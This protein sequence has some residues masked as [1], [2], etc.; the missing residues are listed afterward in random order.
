MISYTRQE[1]DFVTSMLFVVSYRT[2]GVRLAGS[3]LLQAL[4]SASWDT[5]DRG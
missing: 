1:Y 5:R 4:G 2:Q 3:D